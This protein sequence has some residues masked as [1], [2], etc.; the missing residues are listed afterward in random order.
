MIKMQTSP[1]K[2]SSK[3]SCNS[4]IRQ[5]FR[6]TLGHKIYRSKIVTC[7]NTNILTGQAN[8]KCI[9]WKFPMLCYKEYDW[10]RRWYKC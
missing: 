8:F 2:H 1:P 10:F 4:L 6:L 9:G 7:Y 5:P 3:C